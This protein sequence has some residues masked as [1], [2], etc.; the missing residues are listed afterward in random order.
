[1]VGMGQVTPAI[2][3]REYEVSYSDMY[4]LMQ[5]LKI[6]VVR[7]GAQLTPAQE[8]RIRGYFGNLAK[9]RAKTARRSL[10][11]R[12]PAP[13][14]RDPLPADP[15]FKPYAKTCKC[16]DRHWEVVSARDANEPL[17]VPCR[18]HYFQQDESADRRLQ[19]AESHV[20]L[21]RAD[22]DRAYDAARESYNDKV[23]AYES[24][25]KWK[26]ALVKVVLD[27]EE[28]PSGICWCGEQYPCRTWRKLEETNKGIHRNVETWAAWSDKRL[29]EMLE[30]WD[31][32]RA[33][34]WVIDE[35]EP[36]ATSRA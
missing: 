25:A 32:D 6:N 13:K 19:R 31:D 28:G 16:C 21:Y 27:H 14:E 9:S 1:M 34:R 36:P 23:K 35:D 2:L 12:V 20:A 15:P 26:A 18:G 29:E 10:P 11:P 4:K 3:S 22:R 7:M 8:K 5:E 17:C 33:H 24:R 30:R